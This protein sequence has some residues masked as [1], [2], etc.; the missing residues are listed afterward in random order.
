M[1]QSQ[2]QVNPETLWYILW[3]AMFLIVAGN[4]LAS[5]PIFSGGFGFLF[6]I[7][8]ALMAALQLAGGTNFLRKKEGALAAVLLIVFGVAQVGQLLRSRSQPPIY[9]GL[10]FSAYYLG[11]E[12]MSETPPQSPYHLPRYSDG[13]MQ[14]L[15]DAPMSA[16][17]QTAAFRNHVP[18]SVPFIYPPFFAVLMKPFV[19]LSYSTGYLLWRA[20]T[21][22]LLA[23]A[24][25]LSLSLGGV[26]LNPRLALILGVGLFSYY[27]FRD[28]LYLGQ[29]GCVIFFLLAA[30]LWLLARKHT[31]W[32]ALSFAIA[33]LIKPTPV[34]AVPVLVLHRK[35]RWLAAYTG[36]TIALLGF[37][38][39]RAG[40][41]VHRQFWQEV[42]PSLSC[43]APV[44]Q[45]SSLVAYIQ[46]LFLGHVPDWK[47]APA[48]MP[49]HACTVSRAVAVAV[50]AVMLIRLYRKRRDGELIQDIVMM[51]LLG[52]AISPI[53]WWHHYTMALL[54]FI[55]LWCRMPEKG[56]RTLFALFLAVGTNLV[57]FSLLLTGNH[58]TQL[59][60]AAIVPGLTVALVYLR[61]GRAEK[62]QTPFGKEI[63]AD[64]VLSVP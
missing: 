23:A 3:S 20:I 32:S 9:R 59:L 24:V 7:V 58:V 35:W 53:S 39:W 61:L 2:L 29:I 64:R 49:L 21:I 8:L 27:P 12:L 13:R 17:W 46:E 25:M 55:Y 40:W 1:S 48:T 14:V 56:D 54:C 4:T 45:N 15:V 50:Y 34:I 44:C 63:A 41:A 38:I 18:F 28:D 31:A 16:T 47:G 30:G 60:L 42:L 19:H 6:S 5:Y 11:A 22:L 51:V 57:G 43:G 37:S 26:R 62:M 36:W 52:L 10:D 33:T